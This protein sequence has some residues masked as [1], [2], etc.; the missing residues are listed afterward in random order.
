MAPTPPMGQPVL[1]LTWPRPAPAL[2]LGGRVPIRQPLGCA[3]TGCYAAAQVGAIAGLPPPVWPCAWHMPLA[4]HTLPC[5]PV[6]L[7]GVAAPPLLPPIPHPNHTPTRASPAQTRLPLDGSPDN[8]E[9]HAVH[10]CAAQHGSAWRVVA[11]RGPAM[12][13]VA[14][15]DSARHSAAQH[16]ANLAAAAAH[17]P[18]QHRG[19]DPEAHRAPEELPGLCTGQTAHGPAVAASAAAFTAGAAAD[20]SAPH[21][22]VLSW[23]SLL[24]LLPPKAAAPRPAPLPAAPVWQ[25]P[26]A[27]LAATAALRALS[28]GLGC[29]PDALM[30][31]EEFI[32]VLDELFG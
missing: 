1:M 22:A 8:T 16:S 7:C 11:Q 10:S 14:Q 27:G 9:H 4:M 19:A 29:E 32:A 21:G 24:A 31:N 23:E 25:A 5:N 18:A 15:R 12:H 3:R 17:L 30:S 28:P 6:A 26:A 20:G 2:Q 13:G